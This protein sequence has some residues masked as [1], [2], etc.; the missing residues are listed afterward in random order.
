MSF[1]IYLVF[2]CFSL[3]YMSFYSVC[4]TCFFKSLSLNLLTSFCLSLSLFVILFLSMIIFWDEQKK[5]KDRNVEI[6]I[7]TGG[8]GTKGHKGGTCGGGCYGGVKKEQQMTRQDT[9]SKNL[10]FNNNAVTYSTKIPMMTP[11]V[12]RARSGPDRSRWHW[13]GSQ[14]QSCRTL[15]RWTCRILWFPRPEVE[16]L[17]IYIMNVLL[18]AWSGSCKHSV[19]KLGTFRK[20]KRK[21]NRKR[22]RV[23]TITRDRQ[24]KRKRKRKRK[25]NRK[26]REIYRD[27]ESKT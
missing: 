8:S 19:A 24:R 21:R 15:G 23:R 18:P 13:H 3:L 20:R 22:Q 1:L 10:F 11:Q 2:F 7:S 6:N 17:I 27:R 5:Y 12:S 26:R 25:R 14:W 16:H 9:F 4:I